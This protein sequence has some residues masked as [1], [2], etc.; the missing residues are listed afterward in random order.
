MSIIKW[1][2]SK[3]CLQTRKKL[4]QSLWPLKEREQSKSIWQSLKEERVCIVLTVSVCCAHLQRK[5]CVHCKLCTVGTLKNSWTK[6][7][8]KRKK[9]LMEYWDW[10]RD[11][12][13]KKN[14]RSTLER[15][16][17]IVKSPGKDVNRKFNDSLTFL[18]LDM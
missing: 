8:R 2:F 10:R 16:V 11:K 17:E 14:S 15:K 9:L 3:H 6:S 13:L 4:I 1:V 18:Y 12:R 7:Q 5:S